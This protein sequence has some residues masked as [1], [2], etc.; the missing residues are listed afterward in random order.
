LWLLTHPDLR[1]V[2][3]IRAVLDFMAGALAR[4]RSLIEGTRSRTRRASTARPR[5]T[6]Y[7]IA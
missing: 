1:R 4:Q 6:S 7:G 2:A 3:R 5:R